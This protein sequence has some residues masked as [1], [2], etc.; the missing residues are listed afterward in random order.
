MGSWFPWVIIIVLIV[1]IARYYFIEIKNGPSREDC[2]KKF[3]S[4]KVTE[5]EIKYVNINHNFVNNTNNPSRSGNYNVV[6]CKEP[7]SY[8]NTMKGKV[9]NGTLSQLELVCS[10]DEELGS[11]GGNQGQ[12]FGYSNVD[13]ITKLISAYGTMIKKLSIFNKDTLLGESNSLSEEESANLTNSTLECPKDTRL[14]GLHFYS[15][16]D[17]INSIQGLVCR[18]IIKSKNSLN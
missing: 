17:N 5:P 18:D 12:G 10:D 16:D 3:E 8:I 9:N 2:Q 13:G 11:F 15:D 14:V 7:A 4:C 6:Q 1:F